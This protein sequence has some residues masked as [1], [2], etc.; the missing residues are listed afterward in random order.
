M[1]LQEQRLQRTRAYD[2]AVEGFA[3]R[4]AAAVAAGVAPAITAVDQGEWRVSVRLTPHDR[5]RTDTVSVT[6]KSLMLW[7][8]R[9]D[10]P[11]APLR[12]F[13]QSVTGRRLDLTVVHPT[14]VI[15]GRAST[16][17]W[18]DHLADIRRTV[19]IETRAAMAALAGVPG[20][21]TP[22]A[23]A[24][25]LGA[26][27]ARALGERDRL[28]SAEGGTWN[29]QHVAAHL[30]LTRQAV[31]RRHQQGTLL[32]LDV[33]RRGQQYPAWQFTRD[34]VLPGLDT[35]LDALGTHD[36]WSR[37]AFFLSHTDRLAGQTPLD[38]L[39]AGAVAPVAAAA[40]AFLA[41]GAA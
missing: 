5:P 28:L 23:Q 21:D 6:A 2:A 20:G 3:E 36:A 38:A 41:H 4:V 32:A 12:V 18:T 29:V 30:R 24:D 1:T 35:V 15:A 7:G 37:L 27:R 19:Q 11:Q 17:P 16:T 31:H 10:L 9:V 8:H 39:R 14:E 25:P 33:G 22:T 26:A 40:T 34:G 13:I